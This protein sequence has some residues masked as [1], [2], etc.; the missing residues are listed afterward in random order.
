MKFEICKNKTLKFVMTALI[1]VV[2][3]KASI[4]LAETLDLDTTNEVLK[5]LESVT[6]E[7]SPKSD[8][9]IP[10]QLRRADLLADRARLTELADPEAK[11]ETQKKANTDRK[12]AITI[13]E[14]YLSQLDE[15]DT[16]RVLSQVGH[17]YQLS[18]QPDKAKTVYTDIVNH[19]KKYSKNLLIQAR[20]NL[21]EMALSKAQY[22]EAEKQFN[23]ALNL[24]PKN[25]YYIRTRLAWSYFHLDKI[26]KAISL[27]QESI[28]K[29]PAQ[30][31]ALR[32]EVTHDYAGF[33]AH[34]KINQKE[35]E[36]L[37][38]NSTENARQQNMEFLADELDRLGHKNE[39]LMVWK[40]MGMQARKNPN[41]FSEHMRLAQIQYDLGHKK[42]VADEV[43]EFVKAWKKP[44]C[45]PKQENCDFLKAKLRKLLL[46]WAKAEERDPSPILAQA[47][48]TYLA[49]FH[50][51][52]MS[53]W[54]AQTFA[55][56][57]NNAKALEYFRQT[58]EIAHEQIQKEVS[59]DDKKIK[60]TF[61]GS[62]LGEIE[63]A[64]KMQ[65]Q[66]SRMDAYD[67]YLRLNSK[68]DKYT[69]VRYQRA[70]IEYEN[71]NFS[72]AGDELYKVALLPEVGD[73]TQN[74]FRKKAADTSIEALI[75]VKD[76][77]RIA[78]Y[79]LEYAKI[80]PSSKTE[81]NK[82]SRNA[83]LNAES[84]T[85]N[86]SQSTSSVESSLKRLSLIDLTGVDRDEKLR[87]LKSKLAAA[88][89][90]KDLI[91]V[92][93]ISQEILKVKNLSS[94][95]QELA[96]SRQAWAYE[97]KL[98]F[99]KSYQITKKM[100]LEELTQA[101]KLMKLAILSELAG[102]S[103]QKEYKEYIQQKITPSQ[104]A[105][106]AAQLVRLSQYSNR[107]FNSQEANLKKDPKV[108]LETAVEVYARHEDAHLAQKIVQDHNL[109]GQSLAGIFHRAAFVQSLKSHPS[110]WQ[111]TKLDVSNANRF[112]QSLAVR[113]GQIK[114]F[115]KFA[116]TAIQQGDWSM[117]Q[118]SID[119]LQM[120]E[121]K[122][123]EDIKSLPAPKALSKNEFEAYKK[124]LAQ[125]AQVYTDKARDYE[126]QSDKLWSQANL[127]K[128][129][130]EIREQNP[131]LR[132]L[133]I[134]DLFQTAQYLTQEHRLKIH[135]EVADIERDFDKKS[136]TQ[137]FQAALQDLGSNP[138]DNSK[139][140]RLKELAQQSHKSVYVSYLENR[141]ND[142]NAQ[143]RGRK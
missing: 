62:L 131:Y 95:D 140:L 10:M 80:F 25:A 73:S 12:A 42:N 108:Y 36:F 41:M 84:E 96:L 66:K 54:I 30:E 46:D 104:R 102:H 143:S 11:G 24:K 51:L 9:Y 32:D 117:Q 86:N 82:I 121:S 98:D 93:Q 74:S 132:K 58:A 122:L 20:V 125:Q 59:H 127:S 61:E 138:F 90:I 7:L 50:D 88:E 105:F 29:I 87:I 115:E 3:L 8:S 89:K 119:N 123:S 135:S 64:E 77:D 112:K 68:G 110:L 1:S 22:S 43:Q 27:M 136:N 63:A 23:E 5:R 67:H 142:S 129:L 34:S 65:N 60:N 134:K 101:E 35:I 2:S 100:N 28:A 116:Q 71:K 16:S 26:P 70:Y 49:E 56:Q 47:F 48:C 99:N 19:P 107:E 14:Q 55:Y 128:A 4:L 18:G 113:L 33:L 15:E 31:S 40:F 72:V 69:S 53:Y 133:L 114:Q 13:Y 83:I 111:K 94:S 97:M 137:N 118:I 6:K 106:A 130:D 103:P 17:L 126:K 124:Q 44:G 39:A 38:K 57:K 52:D 109:R 75:A 45:D 81:F 141:L 92:I 78:K 91:S 139:I 85:I 120:A 37:S 79:A 76:N 21:G